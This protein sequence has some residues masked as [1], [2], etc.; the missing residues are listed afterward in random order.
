MDLKKKEEVIL[1]G[2]KEE[3]IENFRYK[4]FN[5][6]PGL[7]FIYMLNIA[8]RC[9]VF[10]QGREN[11]KKFVDSSLE[12]LKKNLGVEKQEGYVYEISPSDHE[13]QNTYDCLD[14]DERKDLYIDMGQFLYQVRQ[15]D[16]RR[17]AGIVGFNEVLTYT[18]GGEG[19][20]GKYNLFYDDEFFALMK[21]LQAGAYLDGRGLLTIIEEDCIEG[22]D[23]GE[24]SLIDHITRYV[25]AK[26]A[27][28]NSKKKSEVGDVDTNKIPIVI[29]ILFYVIFNASDPIEGIAKQYRLAHVG[30][31]DKKSGSTEKGNIDKSMGWGL[32]QEGYDFSAA[33]HGFITSVT[34]RLYRVEEEFGAGRMKKNIRLKVDQL[35]HAQEGEM[36]PGREDLT[37]EDVHSFLTMAVDYKQGVDKAMRDIMITPANFAGLDVKKKTKDKIM[38]EYK[39]R[40]YRLMDDQG[41]NRYRADDYDYFFSVYSRQFVKQ[42]DNMHARVIINDGTLKFISHYG[43][44]KRKKRTRR[45]RKKKRKRTRK[46]KKRKCK[47]RMKK[48]IIC[49]SA[50]NKKA[51]R[52]LIRVTKKL[53]RMKGIKLSKCSKQRI[54][55]W[56][57]KKKRTR[58]RRKR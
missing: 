48:K 12:K 7:W 2:K 8:K 14:P 16:D 41:Y 43:G 19:D 27:E 18:A 22:T 21:K 55:K 3:G 1:R 35:K 47:K 34:N 54:K 46:R 33:V 30:E 57:K 20:G 4:R 58:R 5:N 36:V 50:P 28:M 15:N 31:G 6:N 25:D 52:K 37:V 9:R 11:M 56:A 49:L 40:V 53:A 17:K 23:K 24:E 38:E 44:K 39:E 13:F 29:K 32:F 42:K 45:K 51:T 10:H 26:Y